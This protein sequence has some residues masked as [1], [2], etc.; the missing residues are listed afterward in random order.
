MQD[1]NYKFDWL[2]HGRSSQCLSQANN[3]DHSFYIMAWLLASRLLTLP[4]TGF[5]NGP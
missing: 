1:F 5:N 3:N 4:I 2:N